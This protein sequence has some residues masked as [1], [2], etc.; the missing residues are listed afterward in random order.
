MDDLILLLFVWL[1]G[2]MPVS[3][4]VQHKLYKL[5]E[6]YHYEKWVWLGKPSVPGD[7]FWTINT[8]NPVIAV[9]EMFKISSRLFGL[10]LKGDVKLDTDPRL[11]PY[12]KLHR[13]VSWIALVS[14]FGL[15]AAMLATDCHWSNS[16][17]SDR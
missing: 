7:P 15:V 17:L 16:C 11:N 13:I 5:L 14:F 1:I 2:L 10:A 3:W 9:S 8:M 4:F 12:L 6:K